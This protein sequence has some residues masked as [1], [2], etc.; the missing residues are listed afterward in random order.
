MQIFL[1]SKICKD[2]ED[3]EE[4]ALIELQGDLNSRSDEPISGKHI[5][6]LHY[7]KD[8][9]PILIIGHHIM[10]GKIQDLEKPLVLA[11][12]Q[13]NTVKTSKIEYTIYAIIRRK[14][15]FKTRPKPIISNALTR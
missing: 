6:D 10:Y 12:K 4:W 3:P 11:T 8:G 9:T 2:K 15:L 13:T 14:L 5:G 1:K 7:T